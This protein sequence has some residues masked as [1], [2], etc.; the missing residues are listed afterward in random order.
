[1]PVIETIPH[2]LDLEITIDGVHIDSWSQLRIKAEVNKAR[3]V[4]ITLLGRDSIELSRIGGILEIRAG[5]G[6]DIEVPLFFKGVI[7]NLNPTSNNTTIVAYDFITH[8]ATSQYIL[9]KD[10]VDRNS[11]VKIVGE[12]LYFI[13]AGVADYKDIAVSG[14]TQGSSI[15]ATKNMST[16]FGHKTRKQFL[17]EAFKLMVAYSSGTD[18]P[19][20]AYYRWYY[21]IRHGTQMDFFLPDY[22]NAKE[23]PILT[24]RESENNIENISAS[25]NTTQLINSV[26]FVSN[27]DKTIFAD[28]ENSFSVDRYGVHSRL[29]ERKETNKGK[30]MELAVAFVNQNRFPTVTYNIQPIDAYWVDLGDIVKVEVPALKVNDLLPVVGYTTIISDK[31]QTQLTLGSPPLTEKQMLDLVADPLG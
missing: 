23:E 8:L 25:I 18:Y 27:S 22:L 20:L 12:D 4:T 28:H 31:I 21:A 3:V 19:D 5:D 24:L 7:K 29:I 16:L 17:D 9:F 30:L 13:G 14:L 1:M 10:I 26:R 15:F 2:N 6:F 11:D